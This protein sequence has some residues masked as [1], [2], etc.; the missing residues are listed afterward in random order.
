MA[1]DACNQIRNLIHRY[2]EAVD[3]GR[4]EVLGELFADAMVRTGTG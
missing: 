1:G 4:F 2:A 3:R